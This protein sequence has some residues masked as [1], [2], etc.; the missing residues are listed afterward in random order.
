MEE[1]SIKRKRLRDDW[2]KSSIY[3]RK[4]N[5]AGNCSN[6]NNYDYSIEDVRKMMVAIKEKIRQ[7]ELRF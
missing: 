6:R 1:K 2:K 5:L 4:I 7:T 3:I